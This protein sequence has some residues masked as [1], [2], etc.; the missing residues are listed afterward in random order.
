MFRKFLYLISRIFLT[1][2]CKDIILHIILDSL[3]D[4][5]FFRKTFFDILL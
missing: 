2:S 1:V 3:V 4:N 5:N